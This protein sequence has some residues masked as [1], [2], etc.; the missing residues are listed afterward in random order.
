MTIESPFGL[1]DSVLVPAIEVT[2]TVRSMRFDDRGL[3]YMISFW[4]EGKREEE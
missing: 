2:A 3:S 4:I 1:N